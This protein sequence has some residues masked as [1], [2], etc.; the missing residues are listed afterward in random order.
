MLNFQVIASGSKGN[1]YYLDD[2]KTKLLIDPGIPIKEIRKRLPVSVTEIDAVLCTHEH[3]D[4]SKAVADLSKLGVDIYMSQG[5]ADALKLNGHRARLCAS[6]Y[7]KK[8]G[9]WT[10]TPLD[11]VHDA[12]EPLVFVLDS[13][14]NRLLYAT[15][16]HY[17]KYRIP[18][19]THLA[20]ECNFAPEILKT[21]ILSGN[22]HPA[23]GNRIWFNHMGLPTLQRFLAA[24]DLSGVGWIQLLHLSDGNSD[25]SQFQKAVE[26]QTGITTYTT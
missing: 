16:T 23:V 7:R 12:A 13:G 8:I 26:L 5:T 14:N 25:A 17:I 20:T 3:A 6:K 2:G 24:N 1:A 22:L 10:L 4:H 19:L 11:A 15:D 9:S 21:N 18:G